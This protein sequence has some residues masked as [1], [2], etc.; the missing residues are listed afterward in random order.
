MAKTKEEFKME[1]QIDK[2][3]NVKMKKKNRFVSQYCHRDESRRC[4]E[5]CVNFTEPQDE[6]LVICGVKCKIVGDER[7]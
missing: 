7:V 6:V 3:G 2:H 4:N 5:C 1:V